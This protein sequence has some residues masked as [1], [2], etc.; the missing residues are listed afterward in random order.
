MSAVLVFPAAVL[1]R[2]GAA[3]RAVRPAVV[4]GLDALE[5][6][7]PLA[8]RVAREMAEFAAALRGLVSGPFDLAGDE[9]QMVPGFLAFLQVVG[10]PDDQFFR[11]APVAA[12][13]RFAHPLEV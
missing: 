12:L 2:G 9:R 8:T 1:G 7:G 4:L 13:K 6:R 3:V 10:A 5:C 11:P